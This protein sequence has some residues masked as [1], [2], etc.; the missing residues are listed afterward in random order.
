MPQPEPEISATLPSSLG[1]S[2]SSFLC[3]HATIETP[4][5]SSKCYH[6][7]SLEFNL[8]LLIC[9]RQAETNAM[10]TSTFKRF[11][12]NALASKLIPHM[13]NRREARTEFTQSG[14]WHPIGE[15][16]PQIRRAQ[17]PM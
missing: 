4:A 5:L 6:R 12:H 8:S 7:F 13:G 11:G 14:L 16:P 15:E 9:R 10:F 3:V 17:H 2:I 1:M